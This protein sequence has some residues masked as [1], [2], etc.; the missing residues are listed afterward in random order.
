[1]KSKG[2]RSVAFIIVVMLLFSYSAL[3]AYVP[4][5]SPDASAYI[6]SY[7]AAVLNGG[8]GKLKVQFTV[9]ATNTMSS[10]G[11]TVIRIYKSNGTFV[12]SIWYTD[13]GRSGMMGSSKIYHSDTETITVTPGSY[14][15]K[16]TVYARNSSGSDDI[17]VTTGTKT[18]T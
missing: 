15:A 7:S 10:L 17:V 6:S 5:D 18:I 9:C 3:A 12:T 8:N 14:Y 16:V 11:A 1:M 13:A 2:I 4:P